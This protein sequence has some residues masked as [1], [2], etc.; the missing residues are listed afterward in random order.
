MVFRYRLRWIQCIIM[1]IDEA[2]MTA[3]ETRTRKIIARLESEG[4][5]VEHGK[6]HDLFRN[7]NFP[8]VRLVVPRHRELSPG[9]A[10]DIARR[11]GW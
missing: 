8:G 7:P 6:E 9:V 4:W 11:A 1:R 3:P 2:G 5:S 10:R